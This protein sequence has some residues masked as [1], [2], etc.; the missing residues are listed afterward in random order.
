M[1]TLQDLN[2]LVALGEGTYL[3]FKHRVPRPAR[4]AKEVIAFA[5]TGGGR[6]LLG[7]DDN[8]TI[9]G[10]RDATEEEFAL[11]TALDDCCEPPVEMS[12]ERVPVTKKRDV[13]VVYVP[14]SLEK[15]HYLIENGSRT[16]YVRVDE[17]SIEASREAVRL[18]R[19]DRQAKDV[20]FEFGEKEQ[21]LMRYLEAYGRITVLQFATLADI[22]ERRASHTLVLLAKANVLQLHVD[23]RQDYFTMAY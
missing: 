8:G 10:V 1:T 21:M 14:R 17:M 18:M 19:A 7:V 11:R 16:A 20:T 23:A 5:N 12:T 3:E 4:I 15:P 13:I 22:S 9:R 2:Q 6:V